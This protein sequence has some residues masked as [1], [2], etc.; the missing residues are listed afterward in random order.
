MPNILWFY[1]VSFILKSI[2]TITS[3]ASAIA[4]PKFVRGVRINAIYLINCCLYYPRIGIHIVKP[5][6][7]Q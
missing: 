1:C 7:K 4:Q 6:F 5:I 2:D 3:E